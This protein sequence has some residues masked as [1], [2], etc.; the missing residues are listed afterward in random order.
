MN[1]VQAEK[2]LAPIAVFVYN[3]PEHTRQMLLKLRECEGFSQSPLYVFCDG[4]KDEKS[5]AAISAVR[6]VVSELVGSHATVIASS[7]NK[8]LA[9]SIISGVTKLIK[10]YGRVI[11]L[12][13]DLLV[14]VDFLNYVNMALKKYESEES[15]MQI[16]GHMFAVPEFEGSQESMFLPFTTSW[17]WATWERAWD[18]FDE[19][20]EGWEV[21]KSDAGLKR[22]FNLDGAFDYFSMLTRQMQGKSDSWAI[23]WY[24]SVFK[25]KGLVLFPPSSLVNNIGFDGSGT[26]GWRSARGVSQSKR[27]E[28]GRI[29]FPD[30]VEAMPEK[31][32]VVQ[33]NLSKMNPSISAYFRFF[34]D[35]VLSVFR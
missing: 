32:A 16:S 23:R 31:L 29:F 34:I 4:S 13:D 28:R 30:D 3:R 7:E 8:G 9:S 11:V 33:C 6:C 20:A 1:K 27:N 22:K 14:S 19:K 24:W 12:E 21:L 26:N 15:V 25:R 5:A 2:V 18:C 10:K 35:K 17:G